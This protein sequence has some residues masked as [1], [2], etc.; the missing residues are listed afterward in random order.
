MR[1]LMLI[2]IISLLGCTQPTPKPEKKVR[3]PKPKVVCANPPAI[4]AVIDTGLGYQ[5]KGL[6]APLCDT[7]HKRFLNDL[8]ATYLTGT[9]DPVPLDNH[10]HGTNVA[11]VIAK[12]AGNSNYCLVIL[13]YYDPD[14]RGNDNLKNTIKAIKYAQ[15]I[16]A[17]FINYSG[18]G[19]EFSKE[20][21][22]AVK[23]FLNTGGT[24]VAAA[25][26][27]REDLDVKGYYPAMYDKREIAV[28]NAEF[29][30]PEDADRDF[31]LKENKRYELV[32]IDGT[33]RP[34]RAVSSSNYG[35]KI[36]RWE[37][38]VGVE[39]F[40]LTMTGTSQAAAIATGKLIKEKNE[41]FAK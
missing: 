3:P 11:G 2:A 19:K 17:K 21:E 13:Q 7:G 4:V 25:G 15:K 34:G 36:N 5:N 24:F 27:E 33:D 12:Y 23:S 18:G 29:A 39:G 38:G 9:K 40:G 16:G 22:K 1:H 31:M 8:N 26:N 41:C 35:S 10:G 30:E 14:S 28:G 6:N 37:L 32:K 20:E